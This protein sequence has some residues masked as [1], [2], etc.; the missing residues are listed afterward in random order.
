MKPSNISTS[1]LLVIYLA[2]Y[3][4]SDL[5]LCMQLKVHKDCFLQC[6]GSVLQRPSVL[7][8]VWSLP[9]TTLVSSWDQG[10][11]CMLQKDQN[12][13]SW[14]RWSCRSFPTLWFCDMNQQCAFAAQKAKHILGCIKKSVTSKL[15]EVILPLFSELVRPHLKYSI[16][17]WSPQCRRVIHL[18]EHV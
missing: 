13:L 6:S 5:E 2:N 15:R 17:M 3:L 8:C 10:I 14:T 16:Q 1:F 9:P 7:K 4:N 12:S 18:L 11:S